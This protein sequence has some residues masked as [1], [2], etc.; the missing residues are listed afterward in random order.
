[1]LFVGIL[2]GTLFSIKV[3]RK[4]IP[5]YDANPSIMD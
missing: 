5:D 4:P 1:M 3:S 2:G